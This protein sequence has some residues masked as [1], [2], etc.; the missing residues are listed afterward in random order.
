MMQTEQVYDEILAR[1]KQLPPD[2]WAEVRDFVDFLQM[3]YAPPDSKRNQFSRFSGMLSK[4]DADKIRVAIEE[5]CEQ[6]DASQ[7]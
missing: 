2:K 4:E 6:V 7:W 3:K 1:L 5:G